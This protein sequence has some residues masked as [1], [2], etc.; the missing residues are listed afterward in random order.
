MT[1]HALLI[2]IDAYTKVRPL[3]GCARDIDAVEAF[4]VASGKVAKADIRKLVSRHAGSVPTDVPET[5]ATL[6]AIRAALTSVATLAAA[7]ATRPDRVVVW[8]AGHG[9]QVAGR[10]DH[11]GREALVPAD[12]AAAGPGGTIPFLWDVELNGLLA[13]IARHVPL[14]VV[15]DCCNSAGAT[16]A[17]EPVPTSVRGLILS[18]AEEDALDMPDAGAE[19]GL[20]AMVG[21]AGAPFN[22]IA[23]CQ[24]DQTAKERAFPP[25]GR[26]G[27]L[28]WSLLS[29][30]KTEPDLDAVTWAH[31]WSRIQANVVGAV[32]D[33]NPVFLG[34]L[35]RP[36]LGGASAGV[37]PGISATRAGN[38]WALDVGTLGGATVGTELALYPVDAPARFGTLGGPTDLA[39][40]IGRV[41]VVSA[42]RATARAQLFDPVGSTVLS[43]I[44]RARIVV[45]G[46]DD[47][48]RVRLF[49]DDAPLR[50]AL[51]AEPWL[52][53]VEPTDADADLDL[54]VT[55]PDRVEISDPAIESELTEAL[56][57]LAL[58]DHADIVDALDH[59]RKWRRPL[60]LAQRATDL[61]GALDVRL[62]TGADPTG[63]AHLPPDP[64]GGFGWRLDVGTEF[65]VEL[66]NRSAQA[67]TVGVL[68]CS[69][70]GAVEILADAIRIPARSTQI[71][72]LGEVVGDK[73]VA[74][75]APGRSVGIDRLVVV[76]TS[77]PDTT[78]RSYELPATFR[79][80]TR[81]MLPAASPERWTARVA[82]VLM[83]DSSMLEADPFGDTRTL[84]SA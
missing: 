35:D 51:A 11:Q 28:T 80:P 78:F 40:R 7:P 77:R 9:M 43:D 24:A 64:S 57:E 2:G 52:T 62:R 84:T 42:D 61:P 44:V 76:G 31:V 1:T 25:E 69:M 63:G 3:Q 39:A 34:R 60:R 6:E 23:A 19:R 72:W 4:L 82:S 47:R 74:G 55:T 56:M 14:T 50:A 16:R 46:A 12:Y 22:V 15:L 68:N 70:A 26:R 5:P 73:F 8:Y 17:F 59:A 41:R 30:L 49:A 29:R 38:L 53:L 20:L 58:D 81:G 21:A 67:L 45:P 66:T 33:Q 36:I 10:A 48:L 71:V 18:G 27:A 13:R 54:R 75:V 32:A 37:E 79:D 83:Y 65:V